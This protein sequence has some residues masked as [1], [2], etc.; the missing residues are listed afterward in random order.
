MYRG[1][2]WVVLLG[3]MLVGAQGVAW[4]ECGTCQVCRISTNLTL[5]RDFCSLANNEDGSMCCSEQAIGPQ[6]FCNESGTLCY[7]V[8]VGGG[9]GGGTGGGAGGGCRYQ[10]GWCPAEC[11]SCNGGST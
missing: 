6:T 7:G 1:L 8:I 4:A 10:N 2:R 5:A 3:L 11:W 9:G